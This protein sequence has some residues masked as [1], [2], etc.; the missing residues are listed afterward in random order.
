MLTGI[1]RRSR[2]IS[3]AESA[4]LGQ[5]VYLKQ[6]LASL[7]NFRNGLDASALN[8]ESSGPFMPLKGR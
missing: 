6:K 5:G 1:P 4:I 8:A 2:S 3:A 7:R